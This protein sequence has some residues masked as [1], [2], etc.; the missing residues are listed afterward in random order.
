MF[1]YVHV[2]IQETLVIENKE[3]SAMPKDTG[4]RHTQADAFLFSFTLATSVF[5]FRGELKAFL[6]VIGEEIHYF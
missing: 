4:I 1:M 5:L 6:T 3:R 2:Y